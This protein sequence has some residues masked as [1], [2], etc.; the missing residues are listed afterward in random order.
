MARRRAGFSGT[1]EEFIACAIERVERGCAE[2]GIS[3]KL[4]D[5]E[6]ISKV[7]QLLAQGIQTACNRDGSKRL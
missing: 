2:Q 7:A 3:V 4:S 5:P 1:E 6:T